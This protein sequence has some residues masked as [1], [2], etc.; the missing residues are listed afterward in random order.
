MSFD[1]LHLVKKRWV[2]FVFFLGTKT[3]NVA[4]HVQ[5]FSLTATGSLLV[6]L[7]FLCACRGGQIGGR[8]FTCPT[9]GLA[10]YWAAQPFSLGQH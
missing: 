1:F 8:G 2:F 4:L 6:L 7:I 3:K 10:H 5:M 9:V